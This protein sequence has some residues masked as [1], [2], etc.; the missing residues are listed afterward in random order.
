[1]LPWDNDVAREFDEEAIDSIV[2]ES[3]NRAPEPRVFTMLGG[4]GLCAMPYY[5]AKA[6]LM[7][8]EFVTWQQ[9]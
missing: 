7:G 3:M 2:L 9:A 8:P 1:M 5:F 6:G 4:T